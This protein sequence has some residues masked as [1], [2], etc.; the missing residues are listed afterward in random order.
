MIKFTYTNHLMD[1]CLE[2]LEAYWAD[3]DAASL[4]RADL[5]ASHLLNWNIVRH[6]G[7]YLLQNR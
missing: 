1:Q 6:K 7:C 5:L 4:V 3:Q 2:E